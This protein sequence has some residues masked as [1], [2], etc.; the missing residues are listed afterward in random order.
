MQWYYDE[1]NVSQAG[2]INGVSGEHF[3]NIKKNI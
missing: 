3:Y 1:Q 2:R